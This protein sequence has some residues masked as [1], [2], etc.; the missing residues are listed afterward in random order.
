MAKEI[1]IGTITKEQ[2]RKMNRKTSRDMEL[3]AKVGWTATHKVHK[4]K[5]TYSRKDKH[6]SKY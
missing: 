4:S 3:E 2:V 6:K 1:K 5:K